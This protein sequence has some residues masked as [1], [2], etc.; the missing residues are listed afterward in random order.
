[1]KLATET[2][3]FFKQTDNGDELLAINFAGQTLP[4]FGTNGYRDSR[5]EKFDATMKIMAKK[6]KEQDGSKIILKRF[7]VYDEEA[8]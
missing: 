3:A 7:K 4:M 5:T 2:Y 6:I 1:M 8:I